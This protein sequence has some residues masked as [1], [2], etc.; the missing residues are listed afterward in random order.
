[1][2]LDT[3][4]DCTA[5]RAESRH[6][7]EKS[8]PVPSTLRKAH[9][10]KYA[11]RWHNI[12]PLTIR[13][14]GQ[15]YALGSDEYVT[16][17]AHSTLRDIQR[18]C[19]MGCQGG[20]SGYPRRAPPQGIHYGT[21]RGTPHGAAQGTPGHLQVVTPSLSVALPSPS[22]Q[23]HPH[24]T[25]DGAR[26]TISHAETTADKEIKNSH[27]NTTKKHEKPQRRAILVGHPH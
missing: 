7:T 18:I 8:C 3:D 11:L 19:S 25:P 9:S 6:H 17:S 5:S 27:L 23:R 10:Y 20:P 26:H 4:P 16:R 1:M 22:F 14:G 13:F 21:P 2:D 15:P 24:G 12:G